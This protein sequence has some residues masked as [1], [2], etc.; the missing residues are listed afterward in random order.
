MPEQRREGAGAR[1]P[2]STV[3]FSCNV[4][5]PAV[6]H[7]QRLPTKFIIIQKT[8]GMCVH[9]PSLK[10]NAKYNTYIKKPHGSTKLKLRVRSIKIRISEETNALL[11]SNSSKSLLLQ[12]DSN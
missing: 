12:S 7:I 10:K 1:H 9:F 4:K 11:F 6:I 5:L 2:S 3:L 8:S